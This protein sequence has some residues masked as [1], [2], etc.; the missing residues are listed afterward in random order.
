MKI[1]VTQGVEKTREEL[2]EL[3][4]KYM[5]FPLEAEQT[6]YREPG[7]IAVSQSGEYFTD[8]FGNTYLESLSG[9]AGCTLGRTNSYI[10]E[11]IIEELR[12]N[13]IVVS[14]I[15]AT[16]KQILLSQRTAERMPDKGEHLNRVCYGLGGSD[17]N[18]TAFK[19]ARLYWKIKGK[20]SKYKVISRWGSFHGC[21]IASLAASGG[22]PYTRRRAGA[23]PLV[24]GFVHMN[25]PHCYF[26][27]YNLTYPDCNLECAEELARVIEQEG[28]S[29]VAAWVGDLVITA[30]GP[31]PA[32][33]EYAKRIREICDKYEILMIADEVITGWG[34]MGMWTASEYYGV[35]PDMITLAKGFQ[36]LYT[37]LSA[38]VVKDKIAGVFTGDN[39]LDHVYTMAGS[40]ISCACG[41]AVI[42]YIE[43]HNILA[44]VKRK[45]ALGKVWN[46]KL[47]QDFKCVGTTYSIGLEFGMQLVKN[48]K[49][50]ERFTDEDAVSK[51]LI[52]VG[53][54]NNILLVPFHG[55][56]LIAPSLTITDEELLRI[57]DTVREGLT[58]VERQFL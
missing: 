30:L 5:W 36:A 7:K 33:P 58:E 44:E 38:T 29:T 41:L 14:R 48:K 32:P 50:R 8:I 46:E 31:L 20:G 39:L 16:P 42:E 37:P 23:E 11:A 17:A 21:G 6:I 12:S 26:C 45:G 43:K 2:I 35:V 53:R 25:P 54:K 51:V 10:I 15:G 49:K 56:V 55:V 40:P 28:P 52:E 34:R 27:P 9:F 18:E 57:F 24:P 4:E 3:A 22:F 1:K 19:I 13:P 47:E